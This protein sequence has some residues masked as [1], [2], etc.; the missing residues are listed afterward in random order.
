[1]PRSRIIP[2]TADLWEFILSLVSVSP[3]LCLSVP[4]SLS[5]S[6]FVA[7]FASLCL[8]V[9]V[10]LADSLC[11]YAPPPCLISFVSVSSCLFSL[12]PPV[13]RYLSIN[14]CTWLFICLYICLY[15]SLSLFFLCLSL[16]LCLY[17]SISHSLSLSLSFS[18]PRSLNARTF[19][20]R[21][22]SAA[23]TTARRRR[24]VISVSLRTVVDGVLTWPS[25]SRVSGKDMI[26]EDT[27][28]LHLSSFSL[29]SLV[30]TWI[31]SPLPR[32][33][34]PS[35]VSLTLPCPSPVAAGGGHVYEKC[36]AT[37]SPS[38]YAADLRVSLQPLYFVTLT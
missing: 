30:F 1:M 35:S 25:V 4:L 16:S 20:G 8:W 17:L 19:P 32:F 2:C 24:R 27:T 31:S 18:L 14:V 11:L 7:L 12:C 28:C 33:P 23:V 9:C 36:E 10:P 38:S 37:S 29:F 5:P 15:L 6:A 26:R 34:I 21:V 3:C 13:S 22:M